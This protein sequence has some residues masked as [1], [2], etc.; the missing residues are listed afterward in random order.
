MPEGVRVYA[1]G[2]IHG[3]DDLFEALLKQIDAD[4][5]TRPAKRTILVLLG[6]FVDRGPDS[7]SV[8]E[9]AAA[10]SKSGAEVR[11]LMG[12]HEEVFLLACEGNREALRMFARIGGRETAISYGLTAQ[13]YESTDY[14]ELGALLGE[15][16]PHPHVE[17]LRTLE[18]VIEIGDYV[19]VHAGIRP[20]VPLGE[21]KR[22]DLRWIR[23][24]FLR[25]A[26]A[27]EKFVVHGHTI[28]EDVDIRPNRIGIDTGAYESGRLTAIGLDGEERWYLST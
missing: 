3:R 25:H 1:V 22:G 13:Q 6:D 26:D 28:T 21:Q 17:F 14:E 10:L 4:D 27:H 24:D 20:G 8:V 2:D 15:H 23:N 5:A 9:R 16:V 18:D 11:C 19:F 12:N 7:A